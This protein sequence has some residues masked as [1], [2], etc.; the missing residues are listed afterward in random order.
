MEQKTTPDL[1]HL[2]PE[3]ETV[4]NQTAKGLMVECFLVFNK[5][6]VITHQFIYHLLITGMLTV[7]QVNICAVYVSNVN[8]V[9]SD[10][11]RWRWEW[12]SRGWGSGGGGRSVQC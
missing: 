5:A 6:W 4:L 8:S 10:R 12:G 1:L 9:P 2:D 3:W 11:E 7:R